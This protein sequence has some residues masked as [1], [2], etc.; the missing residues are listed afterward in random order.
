MSVHY[1][2]VPSNPSGHLFTVTLTVDAP[3]PDGQI[4]TLPAW[5]PGSYLVR[6]FAMHI[7]HLAAHDANGPVESHKTDKQTWKVAPCAGPLTVVYQVYAWD[8]SVRKAHLDQTHGYFN[9]TSLFLEVVGQSAGPQRVTLQPPTDPACADWRVA[10]TLPRT[11]GSHLG[12]G[13]FEA[14]DYDA[15]IDHPVEMGTFEHASF[16]ARGIPHEIALTGRFDVDIDRLIRDLKVICEGHLDLM[17]IPSDL[18]R[19]LFQ[20]MVVGGGYG[21]LEHRSSTSL[22][23]SRNDLPQVGEEE[24]TDGYRT[25][26][27]LSSHEYF[28]TWNVKRIKPAVFTP[29]DLSK[30][31]HTTLLWAF[32]G[33]TSY[34]EPLGLIRT[35][36][37]KTDSY[38][39]LV[40]RKLTDVMRRPG[41]HL[42]TVAQ[43]SFDAWTKFYKQDENNANAI[44]SYYSKG[45]M[46]ALALDLTLRTQTHGKVTMDDVMRT[47][48]ERHGMTGVGVPE[49]G[50]QAV[51]T[52]LSGLD[53]SDFFAEALHST[54]DA[55]WDRLVALLGR[56]GVTAALRPREGDKDRGGKPGKLKKDRW[57]TAGDLGI[58]TLKGKVRTVRA[59]SAAMRAGLSAGDQLVALDGIKVG[60]D[61]V[62]RI[63]KKAP[64]TMVTLHV[65]RRDELLELAA[66][67]GQAPCDT[68]VLELDDTAS[69]AAISLRNRWLFGA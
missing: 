19:Y 13:Q 66:T 15:L 4:L 47:L 22:I 50:V 49:D 44:V 35:K 10:T 12:F 42:Q 57:E 14:P 63:A 20:I 26:L 69:E 52:E 61:I 41:R 18:D 9:G 17:G 38:L 45:H 24:L 27:A 51:A 6:D 53:L 16:E 32:E 21:G 1:A 3:D 30:E 2:V 48:F 11:S 54:G 40:G 25:L 8:L 31:T 68:V 64:G 56:V 37:I 60:S 62:E 46:V 34:Y 55:L 33:I 59:D 7:V 29:F 58:V 23:C 65:F 43:S 39:E 36:V 5:I 67:V 28:H